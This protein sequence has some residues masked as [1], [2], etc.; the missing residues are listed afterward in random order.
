MDP[1]SK[2]TVGQEQITVIPWIISYCGV[3][4]LDSWVIHSY[5]I[6]RGVSP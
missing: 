1:S 5:V 2:Y 4:H 3:Y 6:Y